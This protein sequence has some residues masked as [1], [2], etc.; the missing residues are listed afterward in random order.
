MSA[1]KQPTE[2]KRILTVGQLVLFGVAFVCPTAPFPMFGIV[3]SVSR[4]HMALAY[5]IAMMAMLLTAHSYGR[6]AAV[7]PAAGSAYTY[8]QRTLHPF[9]GFVAGWTMLLDYVLM[10]L[11]SVI[12]L[13]LTAARFFPSIPQ[14]VWLIAFAVAITVTNLFG[15]EVTNRA[16]FIMTGI[17]AAVVVGFVFAAVRALKAGT[18]AGVLLSTEP[19]YNPLTFSGA[20]VMAATSIAAFSFLGFD[21]ISTLA[22]DARNPRRDIGRA[23]VLVC[24]LCGVIF[25]LQAYLGQLAWPDFRIYPNTETAFLD[26]SRRV[27]GE[28]L[29]MLVSVALVVA[30][31]ASAVTGQASASRLLFGMGRDR[32]LPPRIFA[33]IHPKYSTPTYSV[34]SMGAITL[35]GGFLLSFQ[36][37]AEAVNFGA[38][39][40]FV[41]VNASVIRQYWFRARTR[42]GGAVLTNLLMPLAGCIVCLYIFVN[43]SRTA[44]TIGLIWCVFGL[45]YIGLR[46]RVVDLTALWYSP[47]L[48]SR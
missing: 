10:P 1:A 15:L 6:M 35:V 14:G 34:L 18:G 9:A 5:L 28:V 46:S 2:L 7:Y 23:T 20:S 17:M 25:V 39:L 8:A 30:G 38:L 22:E 42:G 44:M 37:A 26:V 47:R 4:G 21:G 48:S 24:L 12:Y 31:L 36:L 45:V 19:F 43:L 41:C 32:V 33:Y 29:L 3:S 16:N 11:M 27:G 13:A 40:G